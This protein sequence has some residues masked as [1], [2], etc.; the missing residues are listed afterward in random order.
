MAYESKTKKTD[1]TLK[2]VVDNFNQAWNY[3]ETHYHDTWQDCWKLYNNERIDKAYE[4]ITDTFVP[5]TFSTVETMVS[6]LAGSQ[7]RFDYLPTKPEQENETKVL[8]ALV[9]FFWK[10]DQWQSKVDKWVRSMIMYG[11]GVMYIWWDIDRPRLVN[12]PLRDFFVDPTATNPHDAKFMGRR[13]LTTKEALMEM[14]VVDP[15]TGE[16]K[17]MYKNLGKVTAGGTGENTDKEEKD[18]FYGSTLG[19]QA[20]ENQVE[21][22]EYWTKDKVCTVANR[23]VVIREVENPYLTAAKARDMSNPE[24]LFPFIVQRNYQDESLFYGKGEIEPIK[25]QQELLNDLT[26]QNNDAI[27]FTLNPMFTLDPRYEDYLSEVESV[28]GKVLPFEAGALQPIPQSNVPADAFNERLNIKNEIREAT[29]SD[30]VVKGVSQDTS[31]TATEI[32]TQLNQA[33]QR[34]AIKISQI[35]NEGYYDLAKIVLKMAQLFITERF[36]VKVIGDRQEVDWVEF[37]P[38][39]WTGDYE[40]SVLLEST[41]TSQ[42]REDKQQAQ[43]LYLSFIENPYVNPE[44]LTRMTL[45]KLFELDTTEVNLLMSQDQQFGQDPFGQLPPEQLPPEQLP[46][47][48][49]PTG[50][51]IQDFLGGL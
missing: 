7:P 8:N 35:E 30:Q 21:I 5:I 9:D 24:G 17:P 6:A 38:S 4:G 32:V 47:E 51:D 13:Y 27:I 31:A 42:K 14:E 12:V 50:L 11:T 44:E 10:S 26:N 20:A 29:A 22:I 37:E 28:P 1:N 39:D 36:A 15:D 33:G 46:Q 43:D 16:A 34:F 23:S 18:L 48:A 45:T 3:A 2:T 49:A 25:G 41:V 40:P 19:E